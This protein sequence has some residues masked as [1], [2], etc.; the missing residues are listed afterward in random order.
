[1]G[2]DG[3]GW[4]EMGWDGMGWDG[5]GWDGMGRDDGERRTLALAR[6]QSPSTLLRGPR[7]SGRSTALETSR[8][9]C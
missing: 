2:W 3:M 9:F 5:M 4:D 8:T 6:H 7:Q 1:M